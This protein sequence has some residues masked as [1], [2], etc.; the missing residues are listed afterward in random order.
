[1]FLDVRG[2][3]LRSSLA[4]SHVGSHAASLGR[5]PALGDGARR[6][7]GV[8]VVVHGGVVHAPEPGGSQHEREHPVAPDSARDAASGGSRGVRARC[9]VRVVE[10]AR[11]SERDVASPVAVRVD[12]ER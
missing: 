6:H 3:R 10:E 8:R 2:A 9:V 12:F 5:Y 11:G 4:A 7:R 1:M